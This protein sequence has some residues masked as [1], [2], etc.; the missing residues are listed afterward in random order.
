[1]TR[2]YNESEEMAAL[3]QQQNFKLD[4]L[5]VNMRKLK[6]EMAAKDLTISQLEKTKE[7]HLKEAAKASRY[8]RPSIVSF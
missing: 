6:D 5:T 3:L 4:E 7:H 2:Q 8:V 1:M